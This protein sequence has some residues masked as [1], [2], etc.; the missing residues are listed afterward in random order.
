MMRR[1]L[2]AS[3]TAVVALILLPL[4]L[5]LTPLVAV[6]GAA[7]Q[8]TGDWA[9]HVPPEYVDWYIQAAAQCGLDP[10]LLAAQGHVESRFNP[11][12][13]SPAGAAGIA[14]FMPAT[15]ARYGGDYDHDGDAT[16]FDPQDAIL[17]QGA[18]MCALIDQLAGVGLVGDPIA[19]ALAAYNAG[20]G[21]VLA[22]GGV[23][24]S[25]AGYVQAVTQLAAAWAS[26]AAGGAPPA[27][28]ARPFPGPDGGCTEDDPTTGGCLT[29]RTLWAYQEIV[30]VFGP[31]PGPVIRSAVCWDAHTWNPD[32]D[33]PRGKACDLFPGQPGVY[34]PPEQVA[35][36]WTVAAWLQ[37]EAGPL[38][39]AY[40]IWQGK[41]W[42]AARVGDGW[43]P[44]DGAGIY[45]PA[46]PTGGHYD[47]LHVSTR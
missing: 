37:R 44:Y 27:E 29:P 20:P 35:A 9:S 15:W 3:T 25:A 36:G 26:T 39:I 21:A 17:A 38:G 14:Q 16:P 32:S 46:S 5:L 28:P 30:R 34:P 43:R 8:P 40:L 7:S 42:S 22:A 33:H 11:A 18:Y 47:H 19:L 31:I 24:Q 10:A 4:A 45:D 23:P 12:A 1:I 41:I 13:V 6:G 2:L